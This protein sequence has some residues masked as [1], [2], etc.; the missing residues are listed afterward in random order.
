MDGMTIEDFLPFSQVHWPRIR[1]AL[2]EGRYHPAPVN[3]VFIPKPDGFAAT[4]TSDHG[5]QP[6]GCGTGCWRA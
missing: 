3:R 1:A 2:L 4:S 5:G 6:D